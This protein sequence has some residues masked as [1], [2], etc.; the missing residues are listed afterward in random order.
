MKIKVGM[1][2]GKLVEV[3]V[4]EGLS[5]YEIFEKA[6][7]EI[8][9]HEVRLDGEK[10]TLDTKVNNG[11]LL[12][13]MKM[14]KGNAKTI[15]VGLMPG[16]LE[17][18][19][20]EEGM[21]A[22]EI[23]NKANIEISNHEI[24]LDGE[25]ISLDSKIDNGGLLVAMKMIKGNSD[26][27]VSDCTEEEIEMLLEVALPKVISVDCVNNLNCN[28]TEINISGVEGESIII[29]DSM[30]NSVYT[31]KSEEQILQTPQVEDIKEVVEEVKNNDSAIE[32]L[33]KELEDLKIDY[34]FYVKRMGELHGKISFVE[35]LIKKLS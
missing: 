23:F 8:S 35:E 16:K 14:I 31:L 34:D 27:Y 32:I 19:E 11:G 17:V 12:V 29:E 25:R 7:V 21:T 10:I 24:R 3:E 26:V 4:Q 28:L 2:P 1:M 6:N 15:K 5:A 9:N 20:V 22:I 18:V 13:A 33:Q 30:F